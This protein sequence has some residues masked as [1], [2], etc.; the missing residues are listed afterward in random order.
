VAGGKGGVKLG[1][2]GEKRGGKKGKVCP[3]IP[4][5]FGK[6]KEIGNIVM[7]ELPEEHFLWKKK[8]G[9]WNA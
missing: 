8:K 9:V 4:S 2:K 1:G 5:Y 6:K 3:G 7:F